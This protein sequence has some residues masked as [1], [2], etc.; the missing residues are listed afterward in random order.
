MH[1]LITGG[2]GFIGSRLCQRLLKANHQL[3][4]FSRRPDCVKS[5]CGQTVTPLAS[6][7]ELSADS[8]FDAV[9]NLAGE[10]I[11]DKRWS[12]KRKQQLLQSRLDTTG[13]LVQAMVAMQQRPQCLINA[14]AVGY[15]GDQGDI[16]VDETTPAHDEFSHQ[17]CRLWE[18]AAQAAE[19]LGVRVCVVR[20]G[21]VVGSDG[22]FVGKMLLPF[23]LGLGGPLGNGRQWMSWVH[24]HD[25]TRLFEW[26]LSH[27]ETSGVYNATAPHP[28][29]NREFT[30][31]LGRVLQRPTVLPMP[32]FVARAL[33]GE[34]SQLLLTGQR[35]LPKRISATGFEFDYPELEAAL[36]NV[37]Q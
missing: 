36:G 30:K 31:T 17:L 7:D 2:T 27:A 15:Y 18:Q 20:T 35:V 26:L 14:S 5:L 34:M 9:I 10:P 8:Q 25:L 33:F 6:L 1:I 22:G 11:A 28:V 24:L 4:V 16:E 37:L 3:T 23:K 19:P 29:T 21:L 13:K 32:A 12:T